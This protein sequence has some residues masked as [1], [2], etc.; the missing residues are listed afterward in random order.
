ML[1]SCLTTH[2]PLQ[3]KGNFTKNHMEDHVSIREFLRNYKDLSQK[4]TTIIITKKGKPE[5][6][7]IPYEN[8]QKKPKKRI[9]ITHELI[10]KYAVPG[11]DPLLSQKIDEILYKY[12]NPLKNGGS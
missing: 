12:P 7:Y 9:K 1:D 6:V 8:W 10:E 2:V 5:G 3:S 4:N 11:G